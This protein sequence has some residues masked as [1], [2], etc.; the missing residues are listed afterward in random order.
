LESDRL[1]G[2]E[3]IGEHKEKSPQ[4]R[5]RGRNVDGTDSES[6]PVSGSDINNA[7]L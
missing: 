3:K 5:M 2:E 4:N 1:E 7:E 6:Y